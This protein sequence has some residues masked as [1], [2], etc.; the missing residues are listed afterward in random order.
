MKYVAETP[1]QK[2]LRFINQCFEPGSISLEPCPLIPG[3]Q[4]VRDKAGAQMLF[5]WDIEHQCVMSAE[6]GELARRVY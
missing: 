1:T 4:I 2:V 6:P 3:G 5:F